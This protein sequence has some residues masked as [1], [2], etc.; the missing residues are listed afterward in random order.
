MAEIPY[1][2]CEPI[3][4]TLRLRR[5]EKMVRTVMLAA[6]L[7]A[8]ACSSKST[9]LQA[10]DGG[11][12]SSST[13]ATGGTTGTGGAGGTIGADARGTGGVNGA[14]GTIG[15]G[16]HGTGGASGADGAAGID[17]GIVIDSGSGGSA[18]TDCNGLVCV[19]DQQVL[20]VSSPALG[21]TQCACVPI[22]SADRCMDCTCGNP[23]CTPYFA[24]CMGFSLEGGLLCGQNG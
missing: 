15:T 19:S 13:G 14:G 17:G 16:G 4:E 1:W 20:K 12:D 10:K 9:I 24:R 8:V 7:A 23:L 5:H 21:L 2:M 3:F 18:L 22:P 6:L 11:M